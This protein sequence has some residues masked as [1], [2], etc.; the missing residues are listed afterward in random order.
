MIGIGGLA[1]SGKDTLAQNLADI[2]EAD[3]GCKVR[4][5]SFAKPIKCQMSN[6]LKGYYNI[7]AFTDDTEEKLIIRP[8]LV[9]HGEQ[10]KKKFG[11]DIW[12]K[13]LLGEIYEDRRYKEIFPIISDVRFDFEAER[14]KKN[15]GAVIHLSKIGNESPNDIESKNDPL[16]KA[17]SDLSH[18][19]PE[20]KPNDM[21]QCHDHAQILWQMLKES[22]GEKWKKIYN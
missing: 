19:W 14:V 13:E 11:K 20:Y 10:M 3:M 9:A 12:L 4:T 18:A 1:R 5:Y 22:H 17:A 6:L 15:N 2:I 16:V 7:S 21:K 8:L